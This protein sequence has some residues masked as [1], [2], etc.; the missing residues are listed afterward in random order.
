M[1]TNEALDRL[2]RKDNQSLA[3]EIGG[4]YFTIAT[5]RHAFHNGKLSEEKKA[6]ILQKFN[7]KL[8]AERK[9]QKL[10]KA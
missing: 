6:E 3:D 2:F 7:Y 9:W 1:I 5:W 8:K 10:R 4:N